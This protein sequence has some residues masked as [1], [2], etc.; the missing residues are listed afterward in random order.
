MRIA[1]VA[2]LQLPVPPPAYGGTELVVS[3]LTEGLVRA[4][5]EVTLFASGD[6][7]TRAR[8]ES[9]VPR[10]LRGTDELTELWEG[11]NL[12]AALRSAAS[13]DLVHSH[14]L[15]P[16]VAI[17]GSGPV[18]VL[19]TLHNRVEPGLSATFAELGGWYSTVSASAAQ[20][21]RSRARYAGF[22]HNAIDVETYP[23]SSVGGEG[24]AF[25]SRLSPEKAPHV[26]IDVARRAG[27]DLVL[28]GEVQPRYEEYFRREVAPLI[29]GE[30]I[31]YLGAV[32]A[33]EKRRVLAGAAGLLAPVSWDEPFGLFLVEALACGTPVIALGRGAVREIVDD[34]R[35][36]FVVDSAEEMVSAVGRLRE[37]DR[38]ECRRSAER[39]F[40]VPSMVEG[41]LGLYRRLLAA[42]PTVAPELGDAV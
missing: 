37:I 36:G 4:G 30:R 26:A 40:D 38:R 41:Y 42:G 32:S 9:T 19:T 15:V 28:M 21:L 24:L 1:V 31:R 33:E 2:P 13:F 6:S 3:L 14:T 22:V 23:F 17:E 18:P 29:D 34:G 39:R 12:Q 25:L 7:T 5:H 16:G 35:T 8:L 20:G 27:R 11:R 10:A